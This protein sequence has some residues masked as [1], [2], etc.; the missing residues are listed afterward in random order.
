MLPVMSLW[1]GPKAEEPKRSELVVS[2]KSRFRPVKIGL[3]KEL[4]Q[5]FG[6]FK[7][8]RGTDVILFLNRNILEVLLHLIEKSR[9][10]GWFQLSK[11]IKALVA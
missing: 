10:F 6:S 5:G 3:T 2:M 4:D 9:H 7:E 8:L 11:W 1:T